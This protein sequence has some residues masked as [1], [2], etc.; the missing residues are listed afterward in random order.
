MKKIRVL[1]IISLITFS[2]MGIKA[3]VKISVGADFVSAYIWRGQDCGPAAF[4]PEISISYAGFSLSA[5][6]LHRQRETTAVFRLEY[7]VCRE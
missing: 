6:G 7:N 5:W 3:Q 1:A 2:T 4:Q